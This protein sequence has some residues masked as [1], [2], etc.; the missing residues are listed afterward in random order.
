MVVCVSFL[1]F[2]NEV[3]ANMPVGDSKTTC[4]A[5]YQSGGTTTIWRCGTC[6]SVSNIQNPTDSGRCDPM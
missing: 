2:R 3:H 4:Y 6:Q 1:D 5:T